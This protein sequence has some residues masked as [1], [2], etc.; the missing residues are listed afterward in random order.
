MVFHSQPGGIT[1]DGIACRGTEW[2]GDTELK[3]IIF[4]KKMQLSAVPCSGRAVTDVMAL[5]QL[6]VGALGLEQGG[7]KALL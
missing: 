4:T 7:K 6:F 3:S 5:L 2:S 1:A